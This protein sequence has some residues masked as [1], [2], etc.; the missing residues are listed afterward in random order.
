[1][2]KS[3]DRDVPKVKTIKLAE[4]NPNEFILWQRMVSMTFQVH[5]VWPIVNGSEPMPTPPPSADPSDS[6]DEE[7]SSTFNEKDPS[8]IRSLAKWRRRNILACEALINCVKGHELQRI[9]QMDNAHEIWKT[10]ETAY[11]RKSSI[12]LATAK[13]QIQLLSKDSSTS[14]QAHIDAYEALRSTIDNN[15]D[16][17]MENLEVNQT[18]I[19][20]LGE[21]WKQ[22]HQA[23][24]HN[25]SIWKPQELYDEVKAE[26]KAFEEVAKISPAS[27]TS[28]STTINGCHNAGKSG[29]SSARKSGSNSASEANTDA[30]RFDHFRNSRSQI[31]CVSFFISPAS[32]STSINSNIALQSVY[33]HNPHEWGIDTHANR[34][35]TPSKERL[36]NYISFAIPGTVKALGDS[37]ES[38]IGMGNLTLVDLNGHHYTIKDVLHVPTAGNQILSL[39]QLLDAKLQF[40]FI[41]DSKNFL[42]KAKN[43]PF[44]LHGFSRDNLLFI[45]EQSGQIQANIAVTRAI[46][47]RARE[48]ELQVLMATQSQKRPRAE[49]LEPDEFSYRPPSDDSSSSRSSSR[50][51]SPVRPSDPIVPSIPLHPTKSQ[52][53]GI[54]Y[55]AMPHAILS[56]I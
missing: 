31:C 14:M 53:T 51:P 36:S 49:S 47:R 38:A 19:S 25:L 24:Q 56:R 46:Q 30:I 7:P 39:C 35:I 44:Q 8:F 9:S 12:R 45:Q 10:L 27:S 40:S 43:S 26:V 52:V 15:T 50:S 41:D 17:P 37:Q 55:S 22:F 2:T 42:L 28:S 21:S 13:R 33:T 1:M 48:A 29:N 16:K 32:I 11:G 34:C 23:N 6:D 54:L 4:W 3:K 20:S 18:F 5:D